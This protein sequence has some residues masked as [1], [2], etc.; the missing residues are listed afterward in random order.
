ME[1]NDVF[2]EHLANVAH[3]GRAHRVIQESSQSTAGLAR[4]NT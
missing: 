1:S 2:I 4:R 3:G